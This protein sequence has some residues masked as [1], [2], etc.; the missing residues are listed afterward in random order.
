M[1]W[2]THI[3]LQVFE[4]Y[5]QSPRQFFVLPT[6][7]QL[8]LISLS[9]SATC[10]GVR[11]GNLT[12]KRA[13][14]SVRPKMPEPS[15]WSRPTRL[16]RKIVFQVYSNNRHPSGCGFLRSASSALLRPPVRLLVSAPPT[17]AFNT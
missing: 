7:G 17:S 9:A 3:Y 10:G 13:S 12:S 4:F 8:L 14:C 2:D 16:C 5:V 6:Q 15:P 1:L 11:P